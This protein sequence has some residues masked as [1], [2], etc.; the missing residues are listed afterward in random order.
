MGNCGSSQPAAGNPPLGNHG[1]C[2]YFYNSAFTNNFT[3]N[4]YYKCSSA[5]MLKN[6]PLEVKMGYMGNFNR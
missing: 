2:P 6:L 3:E 5:R 1:L 4:N